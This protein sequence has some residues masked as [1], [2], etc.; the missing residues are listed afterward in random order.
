MVV[1]THEMGFA[2]DVGAQVAFMDQ[3][4]VVEQGPPQEVLER[5]RNERTQRFLGLVL[6]HWSRPAHALP[7]RP[8]H[9]S[10]SCSRPA[11]QAPRPSVRFFGV[12]ASTSWASRSSS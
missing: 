10:A 7:C 6:E 9:C 4:V 5:P 1:V 11:S 8:P 3:G 2:R 12:V